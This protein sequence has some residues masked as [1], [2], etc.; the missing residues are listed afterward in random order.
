MATK[1]LLIVESRE[2]PSRAAAARHYGINPKLVTERMTKFNWT[3]SQA[4]EVDPR[5][6]GEYRK[7]VVVDGVKFNSLREA[8]RSLNMKQSTLMNRIKSGTQPEKALSKHYD[9]T[10][11]LKG[12]AKPIYYKQKLYPS[13][14]H[15]LLDNTELLNGTDLSKAIKKLSSQARKAC[16]LGQIKNHSIDD[17]NNKY[18]FPKIRFKSE[19]EKLESK[20]VKHFGNDFFRLTAIE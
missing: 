1:T 4:V 18:D 16:K 5:P 11:I 15:L 14:R 20:L 13:A 12:Q 17:I 10:E 3:L 9:S 8:A 6:K 7:A 19:F 2:F